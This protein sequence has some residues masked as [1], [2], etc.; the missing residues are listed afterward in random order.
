MSGLLQFA[1]ILLFAVFNGLLAVMFGDKWGAVERT[2]YFIYCLVSGFVVA[3]WLDA[4][5]K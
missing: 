5:L 3:W 4:V 2:I 1:L